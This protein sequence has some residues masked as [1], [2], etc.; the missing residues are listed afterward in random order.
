VKR[1]SSADDT[2]E[3]GVA[4]S[5]HE[6]QAGRVC[7]RQEVSLDANHVDVQEVDLVFMGDSD[8]LRHWGV[9]KVCIV[10]GGGIPSSASG[11]QCGLCCV[12]GIFVAHLALQAEATLGVDAVA[13]RRQ[14]TADLFAHAAG[15]RRAGGVA[16]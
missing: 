11:C 4:Q 16:C 15:S 9:R 5:Y 7:T 1:N 10:W 2:P 14:I 6:G 13:L 12:S 8:G 3:L